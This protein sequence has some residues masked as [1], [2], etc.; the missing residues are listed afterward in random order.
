MYMYTHIYFIFLVYV[1]IA[2]LLQFVLQVLH[3]T[4]L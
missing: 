3:F 4:Q 2:G 1:L